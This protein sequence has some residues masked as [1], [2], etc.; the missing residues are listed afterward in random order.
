[1]ELADIKLITQFLLRLVAQLED[2]QHADLVGRGLAREGQ[3]TAHFRTHGAFRNCGV[4]Q[5][6]LH[7]LILGPA[8]RMHAGIHHQADSAPHFRGQATKV[9]V[10]VLELTHFLGQ[11]LGVERPAFHIR[12]K[13][14]LGAEL[15]DAFQLLGDGNLH[16]VTGA[17]FVV[18]HGFHVGGGQRAHVRHVHI[19]GAGALAIRSARLVV[20]GAAG[21]FAEGFHT[22]HH[23][24]GFGQDAEIFRQF[25]LH[26]VEETAG[27][28]QVFLAPF[29]G[30]RIVELVVGADKGEELLQ[31]AL[32]AHFVLDRF[33]FLADTRHFVEA[34]LVYFFGSQRQ[35]GVDGQTVV[36][37]GFAIGQG[38]SALGFFAGVCTVFLQPGDVGVV[39][40]L[41]LFL[42]CLVYIRQQCVSGLV[43]NL[44]VFLQGFNLA[45]GVCQQR[46]IVTLG[47]RLAGSD[48][49]RALD[50]QIVG[51]AWRTNAFLRGAL[52]ALQQLPQCAA[53]ATDTGNVCAHV[54][55][56]IYLVL[57]DH[58]GR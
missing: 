51:K 40:R 7:R 55:F 47:E 45:L 27:F 26:V 5:E 15:R 31:V 28:F 42:Q 24:T 34:D 23:Q 53:D 20:L 37:E 50:S 11:C 9:L 58:E 56:G 32:E 21:N 57:I 4:I 25:L 19:V 3:V 36:V 44:A 49:L 41:E 46:G 16:V 17:T 35:G 2:F 52:G 13:V 54:F 8:L 14:R 48:F 38:G 29:I 1:M 43:I 33:H 10:G 22:L 12:R 18:S 39:R 30:V 6:V